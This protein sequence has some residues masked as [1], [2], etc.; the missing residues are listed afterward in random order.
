MRHEMMLTGLLL[1]GALALG[2]CDAAPRSPDPVAPTVDVPAP[3]EPAPDPDAPAPDGLEFQPVAGFPGVEIGYF[4]IHDRGPQWQGARIGGRYCP[5]ETMAPHVL[6]AAGWAG[7]D[8]ATRREL[9]ERY[10]RRVLMWDAA[11][12]ER[13]ADFERDGAPAFESFATR[14]EADGTIVV[15]GWCDDTVVGMRPPLV[16]EWRLHEARVAPG[17][18]VTAREVASFDAPIRD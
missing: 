11:G 7:A 17:G 5:P 8:A 10:C 1:V 15:R 12:A 18:A 9:A 14:I 4:F 13:P 2:G 6:A 16:R 3:E